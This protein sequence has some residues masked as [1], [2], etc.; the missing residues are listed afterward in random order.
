MVAKNTGPGCDLRVLWCVLQ[1][2]WM[3][4]PAK[5]HRFT[6]ICVNRACQ[7]VV[8][9]PNRPLV[10]ILRSDLNSVGPSSLTHPAKAVAMAL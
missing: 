8:E 1:G 2:Y 4:P 7:N 3:S 9:S 6:F 10:E 5:N